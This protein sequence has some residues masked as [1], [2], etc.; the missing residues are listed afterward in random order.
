MKFFLDIAWFIRQENT[1]YL[2]GI[3]S[4]ILVCTLRML[5]PFLVKELVDSFLARSITR[6]FL[7]Q[8]VGMILV[9]ALAL[10]GLR[11][12]WRLAVFGTAARLASQLRERLYRHFTLLTAEFYNRERTG[13][14]MAHATNDINAIEVAGGDGL[15]LLLEFIIAG[16]LT[17][18]CM[19]FQ[20]N[21][22]IT[23]VALIPMLILAQVT[24]S[25]GKRLSRYFR[26]SQQAF[27]RLNERV[28]ENISGM[29]VVKSFG[30]A[31]SEKE[32]FRL[33]SVDLVAKNTA[34]ARI[35]ALFEPTIQ[36]IVGGSFFLSVSFGAWQVVRGEMSVGQITQ[37]TML[38]VQLVWPILAFGM[39]FN[40][41]EKGRVSY[42]RVNELLQKEITIQ[43]RPGAITTPPV[44]DLH[45]RITGFSY[46]GSA[47]PVLSSISVSII[48]GETLGVTGRTGSGK[49]SFLRLLL[50]EFETLPGE[51][52]IGGRP[53]HDY[54]LDA[55]RSAIG[56]VPQEHFL[57]SATVAENI[58][59]GR[60][61]AGREKIE[62][63]A[64]LAALDR[65]I[66]R[67]P[68]G[69]DTLVGERGVTL[70]GGQK[71]RIS[72]ARA[73]LL[74]PEI[75]ILDDCLSAVD[76]RTEQRL[77]D[78]LRSTRLGKTTL[79]AAH[80]LS[81]IEHADRIIVIDEGKI[82]EQGNHDEL[83]AVEGWYARMYRRQQLESQLEE[84]G[85]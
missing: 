83:M 21:W 58:A 62:A 33:L 64:Q 37:F 49:S 40:L 85:A 84:A 65:D 6:S 76:A 25:Y 11:Y 79:I 57:F 13:D 8:R 80:R 59:F 16:I 26:E 73:L 32:S 23:L 28:Q 46:P 50:R 15:M 39:M 63:V 69:F 53:I 54:S 20:V 3:I 44:G 5:P 55:L 45:Y 61:D 42:A 51:I 72:I 4:L 12:V 71:Q 34:V 47:L 31:D 17:V 82:V 18:G 14:L 19:G 78:G 70:S 48:R 56:Y 30:L 77:L 52:C 1:T 68:E 7:L 27:S 74:E 24:R 67:F 81:A 36:L 9:V 22:K 2:I 60:P 10:Y 38:L 35:D 75:L 66:S 29:R 43:E 41:V